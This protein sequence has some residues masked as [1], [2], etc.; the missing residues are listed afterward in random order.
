MKYIPK[1]H[2]N[3]LSFQ[4]RMD[5]GHSCVSPL[6]AQRI[7]S[8]PKD[9]EKLWVL[10]QYAIISSFLISRVVL[11]TSKDLAGKGSFDDIPS[12]LIV[13][14]RNVRLIYLLKF[15]QF[16]RSLLLCFTELLRNRWGRYK[17]ASR[18]KLWWR[19]RNNIRFAFALNTLSF[20]HAISLNL[21]L[22]FCVLLYYI[23]H[24]KLILTVS[25]WFRR[26][27]CVQVNHGHR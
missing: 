4:I 8:T 12:H 17:S 20:Y 25:Y 16:M 18:A 10:P 19:W 26:F 2:N 7:S 3:Y 27:N 21:I 1:F 14:I 11:P 13:S 9:R 22:I 5:T 23:M 15:P 24:S 6:F